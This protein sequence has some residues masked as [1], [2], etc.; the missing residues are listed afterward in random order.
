MHHEPGS[1]HRFC[2]QPQLRKNNAV[3]RFDGARQHV[4]NYPGITVER[5]EGQ[6]NFNDLEVNIIDLPGGYSLSACSEDEPWASRIQ[7][8]VPSRYR[9]KHLYTQHC[10]LC[11]KQIA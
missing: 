3:Q 6:F 4:G 1:G 8:G 9:Q 5:K 2:R 11:G 7:S 10:S